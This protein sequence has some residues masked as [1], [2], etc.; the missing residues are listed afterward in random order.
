MVHGVFRFER[1][2][3]YNGQGQGVRHLEPFKALPEHV[4]FID[5]KSQ[6]VMLKVFIVLFLFF[7]FRLKIYIYI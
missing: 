3:V 5:P 6:H 4:L 2:D 1:F 7:K